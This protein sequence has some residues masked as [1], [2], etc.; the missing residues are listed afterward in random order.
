MAQGNLGPKE[1]RKRLILGMVGLVM[2]LGMLMIS[3]MNSIYHWAS[4]LMIFWLAGMG[5]FQA[6]AKT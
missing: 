4:L 5:I 3:G 2:G 6:K 1:R